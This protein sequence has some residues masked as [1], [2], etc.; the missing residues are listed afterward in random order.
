MAHAHCMLGTYGNKHTLRYVTLTAFP[1]QQWS[2]ERLDGL[3]RVVRSTPRPICRLESSSCSRLTGSWMKIAASL[4]DF[5]KKEKQVFCPSRHGKS[6]FRY[7]RLW[8]GR[9]D[10]V[11]PAPS[12]SRFR[13]HRKVFRVEPRNS[14]THS[15]RP[16]ISLNHKFSIIQYFNL[17]LPSKYRDKLR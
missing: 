15:L 8:P 4:E 6:I 3:I 1:L 2:H 16:R 11:I 17:P 7:S 13:S 10:Q 9:V 14:V 12:E 5:E